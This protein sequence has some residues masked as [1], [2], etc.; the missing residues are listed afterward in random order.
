[1]SRFALLAVIV[2]SLCKFGDCNKARLQQKVKP[3]LQTLGSPWPD[4]EVGIG[5]RYVI[6]EQKL[7]EGQKITTI[8]TL[9]DNA[10]TW[11]AQPIF[12]LSVIGMGINLF[13]DETTFPIMLWS[14]H[15]DG[16][17]MPHQNSDYW[18]DEG[19]SPVQLGNSPYYVNMDIPKELRIRKIGKLDM[20]KDDKSYQSSDDYFRDRANSYGLSITSPIFSGALG[21]SKSRESMKKMFQQH[22]LKM[23]DQEAVLYELTINPGGIYEIRCEDDQVRRGDIEISGRCK[24]THQ[25]R[26]IG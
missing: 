21:L 9:D 11:G 14:Y 4:K 6:N 22:D 13:K 24:K 17:V 12:G 8:S 7:D 26:R 15:N 23:V 18:K 16:F 2:F 5:E 10:N 20:R 1:M 19:D 25:P 3:V